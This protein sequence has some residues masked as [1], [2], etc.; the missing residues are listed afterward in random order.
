MNNYSTSS[1]R[2]AVLGLFSILFL[3]ACGGGGGGGGAPAPSTYSILGSITPVSG[4]R[5]DSDVNDP[6][7]SY[8]RNDNINEAQVLPNPVTLGGFVSVTGSGLPGSRFAAIGD[9]QDYFNVQLLAGQ[10]ISLRLANTSSNL[11]LILRDSSGNILVRPQSG[12]GQNESITVPGNFSGAQNFFIEVRA[13]AGVSNYTLIVGLS[14][15]SV[16]SSEHEHEFVPGEV[17]VKFRDS[18]L[19]AGVTADSLAM[20][21]SSI[22]LQA[23]SGAPGRSMLMRLGDTSQLSVAKKKL[24]IAN[25]K[26]AP[27]SELQ[28]KLDTIEVVKALSRRADVE[29]ARL[30]YIYKPMAMPDDPNFAAQWHYPLINLPQAWDIS[31]GSANVIV[32]VIDTGVLLNHPDF[33][34]L[35]SSSQLVPG[36]DFISNPAVAVDNESAGVILDG[37][38]VDIDSNPNDPGDRALGFA[39]TFHG[40]HVAGTIAAATNN[41]TG[42][43]G[44][45]WNVKVMPLRALGFGGGAAYDIEQAVLF[46]AGLPNDSGTVPAQKAD[47]INLSLGGS[48]GVGPIDTPDAYTRARAA[49]VIIIAAAGND[50][51]NLPIC[52]AS[53][54]D[55][56]ISVSAVDLNKGRAYYS[57]FGSYVDVAG[58]GGDASQNLNGDGFA[59]AVLSTVGS[60]IS[61]SIVFSYG[62]KQGTSMATPHIAG[63]AALMKSVYSTMTPDEFVSALQSG[64]ITEDLGAT[65][66]DDQFGHGL[67]D[68]LGAV[69]T[70]QQLAA[71]GALPDN[72][73]MVVSPGSINFG[74]SAVN[75]KMNIRNI[76]TGATPLTI[77]SVTNDSGGWLTHT[78]PVGGGDLGDYTFN[79]DRSNLADNIYSATITVVSSV[80]T[81]T[82][83]VIMQVS[84][85]PSFDD[86][87]FHYVLVA[88][89]GEEEGIEQATANAV[90][91]KYNFSFDGEFKVPAGEYL[92]YAGTDLDNDGAICNEGEACGI[93]P[94][95]SP[96][97]TTFILDRDL[98]DVDLFTGFANVF[99]GNA[100]STSTANLPA[101]GIAIKR[102][103]P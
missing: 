70:A 66:R 102:V 35:D 65:G 34:N 59:D 96:D 32:A 3:C 36:Y 21:A 67:I 2:L 76:G 85:A 94:N 39:S 45:G 4:S 84:S 68:A 89:P 37:D 9:L 27:S 41:A 58:P 87:G 62:L 81:V 74:V 98:T 13:I 103:L 99:T 93:Y 97:R 6:A 77:T 12:F 54:D 92:I 29:R 17:I 33:V 52:P 73:F 90:N 61:S 71:G 31:Q 19:P 80:N 40:T 55:A 1:L 20:R 16:N 46:A 15:L 5:I 100:Q 86:A 30:N 49:G 57:N 53:Y 91:G 56:V 11:D 51:S 95:S 7:Y 38:A 101:Q 42:V 43:A 26:Q 72:P 18:V 69:L 28:R 78:A 64:A 22:G 25:G 50:A 10:V 63:V 75:L 48:C 83:P 44:V 8:S 47:V 88:L 60:D 82:I 23:V 14:G 79:V 24:K